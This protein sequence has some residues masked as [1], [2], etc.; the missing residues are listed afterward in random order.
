[1]SAKWRRPENGWRKSKAIGE[2][3]HLE[4]VMGSRVMTGIVVGSIS[5]PVAALVALVLWVLEPWN[6]VTEAKCNQIKRGMTQEQVEAI[7]GKPRVSFPAE[8]YGQTVGKDLVWTTRGKAFVV[9]ISSSDD[10]VTSVVFI[11]IQAKTFPHNIR[12]WIWRQLG[13]CVAESR[14]L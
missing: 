9:L 13:W 4:I 11:G 5:L 14:R 6:P 12:L 8:S 3:I 1:V 2:L 10:R 7:L